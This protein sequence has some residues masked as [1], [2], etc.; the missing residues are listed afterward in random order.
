MIS[1]SWSHGTE[2]CS[3]HLSICM[4][5]APHQMLTI[6]SG[7]ERGKH[8]SQPE[9]SC[10]R[11]HHHIPMLA[12]QPS[13]STSIQPG[14]ILM[15][16][17]CMQVHKAILQVNGK[18]RSVVVKVRH[19]NVVQRLTQD[20]RILIPLASLTSRVGVRFAL[21]A[22]VAPQYASFADIR[23]RLQK[24]M[25]GACATTSASSLP[26]HMLALMRI[27]KQ[28]VKQK[29]LS[30][31]DCKQACV[32]ECLLWAHAHPALGPTG[33]CDHGPIHLCCAVHDESVL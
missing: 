20:F 9:A 12:P 8:A 14:Y 2:R 1:P 21:A 5:V 13:Y 7:T 25:G 18:P 24:C 32:I 29:S 19:P 10:I 33:C 3:P 4:W 6:L 23:H 16:G 28:A 26:V 31:E 30:E 27:A 17:C 22:V 11:Q 15:T